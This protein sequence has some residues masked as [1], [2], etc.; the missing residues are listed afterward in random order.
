MHNSRHRAL[1]LGHG[2][3]LGGR[4]YRRL[5]AFESLG[6]KDTAEAAGGEGMACAESA[7]DE[8]DVEG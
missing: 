8:G 4:R 1:G 5:F 7:S 6:G 2:C 3:W